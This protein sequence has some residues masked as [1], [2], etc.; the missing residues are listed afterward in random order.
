MTSPRTGWR[1]RLPAWRGG[2]RWLWLVAPAAI[3]AL[4]YAKNRHNTYKIFKHVFWHL[5]ERRPLY[6]CY[7]EQYGDVNLYGPI[8]GLVI[9]P[10]ALWPDAA[11]GLLWNLAMSMGLYL[12]V[13]RLRLAPERRVLLLL[14]CT[15]ELLNALW[16][17]QFNPAV[18]ALLLLTFAFVEE[19]RDFLAPLWILIGA[20]AKI[21][22]AVGLLFLLFARSRRAFLAGGVA[23]SV[24]LLVAPMAISSPEFVL[25]SY[26]DWMVALV[27]KNLHN[28]ALSTSQDISIPGV[29]RRATGLPL[30]GAWFYLPGLALLL[31]PLLRV[32]QYRHR[33]F[34]V[35]TLAS[36][37]M[38][39]VLFSSGSESSTYVICA[40]GAGLWLAQ[41]EAPFRP[42][43]LV[44]LVALLLAG[45]APTDLLSVPV[46][47]ATN[48]YALKAIPYAVTWLLLCRDLLTR[49]FGAD[50]DFRATPAGAA[51][52]GEAARLPL[53]AGLSSAGHRP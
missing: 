49:D 34:R 46:R 45:L 26:Q 19:G 2:L 43:N 21:Y 11:G 41:Q 30:S 9:A 31:A 48:R 50:H 4:D 18:A 14:V 3:W 8:F 25:R 12:A 5:L 39:I 27:G 40:A 53:N 35:L 24:L 10:F 1:D 28:I 47:L 51:T 16:S 38:F 17:N 37:L 36:L 33:A 44:L 22:S 52:P 13:G 7:P 15:V 23:W 42:R 20:F 6:L 29:I 32:G